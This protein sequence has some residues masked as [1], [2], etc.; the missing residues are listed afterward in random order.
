MRAYLLIESVH[1]IGVPLLDTDDLL[2]E[3]VLKVMLNLKMAS[4]FNRFA[5]RWINS[6]YNKDPLT[7]S[8]NL[9]NKFSRA[10][11]YMS[12]KK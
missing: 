2:V 3:L 9:A 4:S 5:R 12:M 8:S 11:K 10:S 1:L 6:P 7:R